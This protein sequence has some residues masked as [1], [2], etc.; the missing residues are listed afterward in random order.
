M[1]WP[2]IRWFAHLKGHAKHPFA[3]QK[4]E[5]SCMQSQHMPLWLNIYLLFTLACMMLTCTELEWNWSQMAAFGSNWRLCAWERK[6]FGRIITMGSADTG[7][8]KGIKSKKKEEEK[9]THMV[10]IALPLPF[11]SSH[12]YILNSAWQTPGRVLAQELHNPPVMYSFSV[13]SAS[14]PPSL[15]CSRH[16]RCHKVEIWQSRP[17]CV[18]FCSAPTPKTALWTIPPCQ[19]TLMYFS[20]VV[21]AA[22]QLRCSPDNTP[23]SNWSSLLESGIGLAPKSLLAPRRRRINQKFMAKEKFQR[24]CACFFF[25]PLWC[26]DNVTF[27]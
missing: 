1:E 12:T 11:V 6:A 27:P 26:P 18:M 14:L 15:P 7:Y 3:G 2:Q 23:A 25:P 13:S 4:E 10:T 24:L 20:Q 19:H 16:S 22:L 21:S 17:N 9:N 5:I 8:N